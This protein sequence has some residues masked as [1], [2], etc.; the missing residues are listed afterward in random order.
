MHHLRFN[1]QTIMDTASVWVPQEF[2]GLFQSERQC[3]TPSMWSGCR[4]VC[5]E[6]TC[7]RHLPIY[8]LI[9]SYLNVACEGNSIVKSVCLGLVLRKK[10]QS[11]ACSTKLQDTPYAPH[12]L[13]ISLHYIM[14]N[15]MNLHHILWACMW[16]AIEQRTKSRREQTN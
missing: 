13:T 5:V 12:A 8:E 1:L 9:W 4:I 16:Q 10:Q 6:F 3:L 2:K 7:R 11:G 14:F 15:C